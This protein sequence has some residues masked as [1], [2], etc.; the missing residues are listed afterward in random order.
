MN[1]SKKIILGMSGGVDSSI[2]AVILK[3]MGY[4]VSG[5]FMKNWEED[6]TNNQCSS[7]KEPV[8]Y[9]RTYVRT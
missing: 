8:T 6:D 5:L 4:K 7:K 3:D 2:S 9:V 1:S